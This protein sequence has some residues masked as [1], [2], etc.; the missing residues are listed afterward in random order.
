[1]DCLPIRC[2]MCSLLQNAVHHAQVCHCAACSSA[3]CCRC[4]HRICQCQHHLR[5]CTFEVAQHNLH[6]HTRASTHSGGLLLPHTTQQH[7]HLSIYVPSELSTSSEA[8]LA[9][10]SIM[11]HASYRS[12]PLPRTSRHSQQ[13]PPPAHYKPGASKFLRR[14]PSPHHGRPASRHPRPA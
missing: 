12:A 3:C 8:W 7:I 6:A 13:C 1:M 14:P 2:R 10:A 4:A 5:I 9:L 11:Q